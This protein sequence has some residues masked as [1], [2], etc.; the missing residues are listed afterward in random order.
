MSAEMSLQV[1][2]LGVHFLAPGVRAFMYPQGF[3]GGPGWTWGD[4]FDQ[5]CTRESD[6]PDGNRQ[7]SN[8]HILLVLVDGLAHNGEE[9]C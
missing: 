5:A 8:P 3:R 7:G 9:S 1:A 6:R 2:A 4:G